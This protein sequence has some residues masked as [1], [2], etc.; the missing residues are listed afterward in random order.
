M[1]ELTP[2]QEQLRNIVNDL[3]DLYDKLHFDLVDL[4]DLEDENN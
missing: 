4:N 2:E 1:E 3:G